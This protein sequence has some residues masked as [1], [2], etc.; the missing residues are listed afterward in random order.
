VKQDDLIIFPTDKNL[1]PSVSERSEYIKQVLAE[2]LLKT[3]NY[4]YLDRQRAELALSQQK[5]RF[6]GIHKQYADQLPSEAE[7]TYFERAL[8]K[9][10]LATLRTPQFYGTYKVHKNG[11]AKMRPII[12]SVNSLSEVFSK[13]VDYWLKQLVQNAL[14][15][16]IRDSEAL[17]ED[18]RKAFPNGLPKGA[19]LFSV[20]AVAMY[21]NI[22][23]E[24]GIEV[25]TTW[26][27]QHGDTLPSDTP[28][29]F[30]IAALKEIM[31]NN[32]FQFGD[33]FWR[34]VLGCAMGT[35]TAVNYAYLY[36][37]L[38][39]IQRLLKH[40]KASLLFFKR[41]ID[42]G[43]GVFLPPP[44]GS[45]TAWKHFFAD[46]NDWGKL[47]WTCDGHGD[48]LVVLDLN[49]SI[50]ANRQ[51]TFTTFQKELNLYLYI[52][53]SSAHPRNML[54]SLI[55]GRLRAYKHQNT[56]REDY[57][58]F[59]KLFAKRLVDRGWPP[60]TIL[61]LF[62]EADR[63]LSSQPQPRKT[64][65]TSCVRPIIFHLPYHPRG[66][67]RQQIRLLYQ[68]TIQPLIPDR[69]LIVAVSRPRNLRDRVCSTRLPNVTGQNPSDFLVGGDQ[70]SSPRLLTE[71]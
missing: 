11:P 69:E 21:S 39:E 6:I 54:R 33:T 65:R 16:H 42:D 63:L 2:H 15:T 26:L 64:G 1:G 36:V 70:S 7:K 47:S 29:D 51:L 32:I 66:I 50:A 57:I 14:P 40:H 30:I 17:Q 58:H 53:P 10:H 20:D 18:L 55:F 23:T 34:Q 27:K 43:I 24:H 44:D 13:W 25:I 12:S 52:P 28:V 19:K 8:S 46:L 60:H 35:S 71:N 68:E 3:S 4:E 22:D 59:A 56:N 31:E 49:I 37:G 5:E 67:Q 62:K 38:L 41:F 61:P 9:E 45:D 48:S